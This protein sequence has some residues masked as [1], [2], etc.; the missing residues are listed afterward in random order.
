MRKWLPIALALCCAVG[1]STALAVPGD[2]VF[3]R[4][5]MQDLPNAVFPHWFHRIRFRCFVCHPRIFPMEVTSEGVTMDAIGEGKF[6]GACHNDRIAWRPTFDN[7]R[8]CH[9]TPSE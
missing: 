6:C 7:C 5:A 8:R 1:L 9:V 2:I 3:P 4:Q